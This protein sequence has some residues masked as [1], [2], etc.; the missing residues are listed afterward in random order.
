MIQKGASDEQIAY[1]SSFKNVIT[2]A[3]GVNKKANP[4]I[5]ELD[6]YPNDTYLLCSDGL[7][8]LVCED[9][10][11]HIMTSAGNDYYRASNDLV[12]AANTMGGTDNIS[13]LIVRVLGS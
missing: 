12:E 6:V 13:V 9:E 2:R 3:L 11:A 8:D 5:Q 4:D 10:V 1:Y 7:T